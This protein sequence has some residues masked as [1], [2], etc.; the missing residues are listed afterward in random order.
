MIHSHIII[1][2][3]DTL[4]V[5]KTQDYDNGFEYFRYLNTFDT[6]TSTVVQIFLQITTIQSLYK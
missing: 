3:G 1:T 2:I 6:V 4:T 5:C